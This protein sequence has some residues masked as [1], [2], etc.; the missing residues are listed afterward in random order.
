MPLFLFTVMAKSGH[1]KEWPWQGTHTCD[2]QRLEGRQKLQPDALGGSWL[3][4]CGSPLLRASIFSVKLEE[5]CCWG[6]CSRF[7]KKAE[8]AALCPGE[9]FP[10]RTVAGLLSERDRSK[11]A[12]A[13]QSFRNKT[14]ACDSL[15][16]PLQCFPRPLPGD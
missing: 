13:P 6:K 2:A 5:S 15:S 16:Q 4:T 10:S 3:G 8:D 1:R 12:P 7:E 9:K 14:W 11:A